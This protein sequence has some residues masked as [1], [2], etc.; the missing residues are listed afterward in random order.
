MPLLTTSKLLAVY[1]QFGSDARTKKILGLLD[2]IESNP[3]ARL[4]YEASCESKGYHAVQDATLQISEEALK[5]KGGVGGR[6]VDT[7]VAGDIGLQMNSSYYLLTGFTSSVTNAAFHI[8]FENPGEGEV[9]S[10]HLTTEENWGQVNV[11]KG[12]WAK[13]RFFFKIKSG[14]EIE[15]LEVNQIVG[16]GIDQA[17]DMRLGTMV[18]D[19]LIY[20]YYI[21]YCLTST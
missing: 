3:T 14:G 13:N 6:E 16:H 10:F 8:R 11:G 12:L 20:I 17:S 21:M 4:H 19:V 2:A 5:H 18:Q 1:K 15:P 9:T 7:L